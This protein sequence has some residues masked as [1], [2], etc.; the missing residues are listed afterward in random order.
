M[1]KT[2]PK[3]TFYSKNESILKMA[4]IGHD[5]KAIAFAKRSVWVKNKKCQKGAKNNSAS[6][7]ELSCA[8]NCSKKKTFYSKNESILKMAKIGHDAK[9]IA[10]AKWSVWVKN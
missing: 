8:K 5:A 9:A 4:K 10:F 1:Q 2:A 3:K 7:L 6:T